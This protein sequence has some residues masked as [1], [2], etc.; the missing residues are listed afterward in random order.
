VPDGWFTDDQP[1]EYAFQLGSD[2]ATD[3]IFLFRDPL[4]HSQAPDCPMAADPRIGTSPAALTSWIASLPGLDAPEPTPVTVGG[5]D[6]YRLEVHIASTWKHPCP[7]SDG[8]PIVPLIVGSV[9]GSGP[10]WGVG[11]TGMLIYVLDAGGGGRIWMDV[12]AGDRMTFDDTVKRAMPVIDS[13]E[14]AAP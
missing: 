5:L 8:E 14:F 2:Q 9:P 4:A 6:G 13:I 12:E 11:A 10:D 3:G 1:T 7:Y